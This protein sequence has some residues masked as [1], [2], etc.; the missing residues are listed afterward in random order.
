MTSFAR[1]VRTVV[2]AGTM[3]A[4]GVVMAA[5]SGV[6][7]S[8][9]VNAQ[10]ASSI[11]VQGN[12]RIEADT[13]RSYFSG[14]ELTA[15][16]VDEGIKAMY[17]TGLFRDV[18]VSRQG[19][20]LVVQVS[21][22]EVINRVVFEGNRRLKTDQLIG[23]IESKPRGTFSRATVQSDTSAC[24]TSIAAPAATRSRSRRRRSSSRMAAS[25]WSSRSTRARRPPSGPSIS[26]A[27]TPS[28]A[29]ASS[30]S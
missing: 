26:S 13:V 30:T 18:R 24:M 10:S 28:V 27:T 23:E 6:V 7:L 14:G 5:T 17:A 8:T 9:A 22:N 19:G 1:T 29:S 20:R 15:A 16:R 25:T 12:R 11:I 4:V 2:I 21:E 3:T